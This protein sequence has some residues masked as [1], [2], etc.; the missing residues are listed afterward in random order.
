MPLPHEYF[1]LTPQSFKKYEILTRKAEAERMKAE[2]TKKLDAM[3]GVGTHSGKT[4]G[5]KKKG[6]KA[7]STEPA[8][9]PPQDELPISLPP[10]PSGPGMRVIYPQRRLPTEAEITES[11]A[12]A[13][14]GGAKEPGES[15]SVRKDGDVGGES[16]EE[17]EEE[18]EEPEEEKKKKKDMKKETPEDI[19]SDTYNGAALD[20]YKWSQTMTDIDVRV[21]VVPGTKGKDVTVE[22]KNDHLKVILHKPERKVHIIK[23]CTLVAF[24]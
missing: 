2:Q 4:K 1:L 11:Q 19:I 8:Q 24:R 13:E 9:P 20:D 15:V 23:R 12:K 14:V 5:K 18:E 3:T 10:P 22:I 21:P 7:H 6:G 17:E 16:E